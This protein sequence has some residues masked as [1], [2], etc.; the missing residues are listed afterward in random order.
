MNTLA[1]DFMGFFNTMW[2]GNANSAAATTQVIIEWNDGS[3]DMVVGTDATPV[4]GAGSHGLTLA[5]TAMVIS[6]RLSARYRGGHP[7]T[8]L[9]GIDT[10]LLNDNATWT[11]AG[12]SSQQT[13]VNTFLSA[14]D[15]IVSAPFTSV[16]LGVLRQFAN[17]GSETKPDPTFLNPPQFKPFTSGIV[18][19]GIAS[20]RRRF[21]NNLS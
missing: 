9:A 7:R 12:V 2:R 1:H 10:L 8:Y 5:S 3:G 4:S 18:K 19:P 16:T 13:L 14:V 6:W 21:G 17:G 20:Q 11:T 15:G